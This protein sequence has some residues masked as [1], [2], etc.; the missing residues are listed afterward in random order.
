MKTTI[1]LLFFIVLIN[2]KPNYKQCEITYIANAGFL[3]QTGGVKILIDA[4]HLHGP[5]IYDKPTIGL[6]DSIITGKDIFNKIN[7]LVFTHFHPD[8]FN[9]S[10][11][12]EFLKNHIETHVICPQQVT[13]VLKN[14]K[15]FDLINS[16]LNAISPDTGRTISKR[17]AGLDFTASRVKHGDYE[18]ENLLYIF[19]L[20]GIK[21]MHSG[22]SYA[23]HALEL[24]D[25]DFKNELID[26]AIV[27]PNYSRENFKIAKEQMKINQIILCH[28]YL[29]VF[30]NF[31]RALETDTINLKNVHGYF[32]H[33]ETK[34]FKFE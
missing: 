14:S 27:D 17:I 16:R 31:K 29:R 3:I 5:D 21:I 11:T 1:L 2:C 23:E 33:L 8:H 24:T 6:L 20:N 18:V 22:D 34:T 9:D 10:L 15:D 4:L 26:I 12:L 7:F 32:N 28:N 19:N 30:E 25:I 13:D